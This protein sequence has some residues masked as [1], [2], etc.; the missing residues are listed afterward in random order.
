MY[1]LAVRP[2]GDHG[3]F[4]MEYYLV[5]D[6][7]PISKEAKE[8][9]TPLE[10]E[11][12]LVFSLEQDGSGAKIIEYEIYKYRFAH[13][14]PCQKERAYTAVQSMRQ[15]FIRSISECCRCPR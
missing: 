1:Y 2:E 5:L 8:Y 9:G 10:N 15:N 3:L 6:D 13:N 11:Q 4:P 12:G 14:L 7:A